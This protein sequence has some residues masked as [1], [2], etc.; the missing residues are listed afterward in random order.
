[1]NAECLKGD[2]LPGS[3]HF[4]TG[5]FKAEEE[6]VRPRCRARTRMA[7]GPEDM[8]EEGDTS[9]GP[10]DNFSEKENKFNVES[11]LSLR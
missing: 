4:V 1:M 11:I 5:G 2:A 8:M 6:Q 7:G 9:R 10:Y 3:W